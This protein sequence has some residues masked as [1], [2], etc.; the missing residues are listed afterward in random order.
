MKALVLI[1]PGQIEWREVDRPAVSPGKASVKMKAIALNRRDEWIKEGKY[2]NIRY[3]GILGSD[4]SGIVDSVGD[5]KDNSW[6]GQ[7]VVIN[8]NINWGPDPEYSIQEI[9]YPRDACQWHIRRIWT[10]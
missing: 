8:P 10:I 4:G 5:E 3:G 6:V 2:P 9:F 1:G 7:E